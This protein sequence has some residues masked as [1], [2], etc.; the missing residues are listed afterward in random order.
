MN[1]TV[2]GVGYVGLVQAVVLAD[3]GHNVCCVDVDETKIE[4]LKR[5]ELPIFEPGLSELVLSNIDNKMI[6]FTTDAVHG[7]NHAEL[8]FIAV[9]TPPDEDGSADLQYVLAVAGTIATHMRDGKIVINKSTVPV[10][11]ADK[12]KAH[13]TAI[14]KRRNLDVPLSVASNPEFLKE[15]SAL[16]DCMRPERIIVGTDS[17]L[18]EDKIRELYEPFS[19]NRDK[20]MVMDVRSAEF[21]K[22]AANCMLATKISFMNEMSNLAE[23][24]GVDIEQVRRGIG[25]DSRIGYQFIYPG[26]G[27]GGSCFPKDVQALERSANEIGYDAKILKAVESVN[28]KQ[29]E[30]LFEHVSSFYGGGIAGKTFAVWGLSFKPNTDD[31]R[32]ASSRVLIEALWK[33]GARIQA[34]DPEAMEE[35]QRLYGTRDDFT[36]MGTKEAALHGADALAIV[37]EWKSFR[38]PDFKKMSEELK[39][40]VI[41]DGRNLYDP[42]RVEAMGL[43]YYGIGRGRSIR[44]II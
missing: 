20:I 38:V 17:D 19:R 15:G 10:G 1:V 28:Y 11:T 41:F 3:V 7:T 29:K 36:L 33:A 13:M 22:Y 2:F 37:T 12:V 4:A 26:C 9:G 18:V 24:L 21:T 42:V 16:E 25:S 30:K 8:Q 32:E 39:D 5:G 27:Y 14:L 43:A 40:K 6:D 23:R 35:A 44:K 31:M 34:Y